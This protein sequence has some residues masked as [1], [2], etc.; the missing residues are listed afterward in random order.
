MENKDNQIYNNIT[1]RKTNLAIPQNMSI[2]DATDSSLLDTT[3]Q[4]LP[5]QPE[6]S[7]IKHLLDKL[8][9]LEEKLSTT[10]EEIKKIRTENISLTEE[11]QKCR[12]EI[13]AYKKIGPKDVLSK[14]TTPKS[15]RKRK[16]NII[17]PTHSPTTTK[18]TRLLPDSPNVS[19]NDATHKTYVDETTMSNTTPKTSR[20]T[21][22][23][24]T[25]LGHTQ[26]RKKMCILSTNK[27]NKVLSIAE[28]TFQNKF[29]FCHY[30]TT[31]GKI[32]HVLKG[33]KEKLCNFT[34]QDYCIVFIGEEDFKLTE[35]YLNVILYIRETLLDIKHTNIIMCLPTYKYTNYASLFNWRVETFNNLLYLDALTYEHVHLL[36]SNLNLSC[37]YS[38]YYRR[39]GTINNNG[40]YTIF[41]DILNLITDIDTYNNTEI[42]LNGYDRKSDDEFFLD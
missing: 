40:L 29:E 21:N 13:E 27:H 33:I 2:L 22:D 9:K 1:L 30:L 6:N 24:K 31:G 20:P 7:T 17:S 3:I 16:Q 5:E 26:I 37:D 34:L 35:N 36:D 23:L 39:T 12:L 18:R 10:Y 32:E 38:M 14:S 11:L 19:L 28:N 4:S 15:T 25:K 8:F 42:T 41:K